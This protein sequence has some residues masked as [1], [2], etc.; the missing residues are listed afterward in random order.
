MLSLGAQ[1]I[2]M[3][4]G[5]VDMR[6]SFDGLSDLVEQRFPGQ[7]LSGS[8]FVFVNRRRTMIKVLGWHEDGLAIWYKRLEAGTFKV[9]WSGQAQLSRREFLLVL[10]GVSPRRL[11]RRLRLPVESG[12]S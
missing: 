10:E 5:P 8:L 11:N 2:F 1:A 9:S 7:L 3:Y 6:K 12:V 4:Q